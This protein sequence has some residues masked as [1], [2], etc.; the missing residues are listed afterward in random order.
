MGNISARA[1]DALEAGTAGAKEGW[2]LSAGPRKNKWLHGRSAHRQRSHDEAHAADSP[3]PPI[4]QHELVPQGEPSVIQSQGELESHIAVLRAAGRF[5]FDTE[6]IGE[7]SYHARLCLIQTATAREVALI[8]PLAPKLDLSGLWELLTDES[9]EKIVHAGEQDLEPVL[10]HTGRPPANVLDTQV[11]AAFVGCGYPVGMAR[12]ILELLGADPGAGLT[13][14]Q[15]DRRPLSRV[16]ILYAANDVRYLPLLC[17]RLLEK[18]REAG[19]FDWAMEECRM[20]CAAERF[21]VNPVVQRSRVRGV[22]GLS[23]RQLMILTELIAWRERAAEEED[24]PPRSMVKD[25]ILIDMTYNPVRSVGE[26]DRVSGLPRPVEQRWGQE[27][28]EATRR[29]LEA[30][31]PEYM[32]DAPF[33]RWAHRRKVDKAWEQ[34]AERCQPRGIDA[35][36]AVSKREVGTFFRLMEIGVPRDEAAGRLLKGWRADLFGEVFARA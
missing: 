13:F 12:M 15:W 27:M 34:A 5:A 14:S 28:V 25:A 2:P 26:L 8:D 7:H 30:P 23:P 21:S 4:L 22:D 32:I 10:R 29:G 20:L 11:I 9:I 36:I 31:L 3:L 18:A 17:E 1:C 35:A 24:L 6:F 19:T 33:D 16:Q